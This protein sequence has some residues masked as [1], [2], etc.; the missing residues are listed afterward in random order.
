[1]TKKLIII[2][3]L[4]V[5]GV[6]VLGREYKVVDCVVQCEE[7]EIETITPYL[8]SHGFAVEVKDDAAPLPP[9]GG[10]AGQGSSEG[11][12]GDELVAKHRGGGSYSVMRGDSEALQGLKKAEAEEFNALSAEDRE[13][14]LEYA[15][16]AKAQA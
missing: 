4:N 11:G 1:M 3:G 5:A 10:G 14:A 2:A 6:A 13:K 9:Q 12:S 15:L 8:T 16:A 7:H